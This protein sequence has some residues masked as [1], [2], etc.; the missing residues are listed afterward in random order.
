MAD[1]TFIR[2]SITRKLRDMGDGSFAE[3]VHATPAV[4]DSLMAGNSAAAPGAIGTIVSLAA[5]PAGVYDVSFGYFLSGTTEAALGNVR[6][7]KQGVSLCGTL[8]SITGAPPVTDDVKR[9]TLDGTQTLNL[10]AI[11]AATAGS[12]YNGWIIATRVG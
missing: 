3:V 6:L 8:P 11:V 1:L 5:P 2:D 9:V 7:R 12:V 10:V 4:A